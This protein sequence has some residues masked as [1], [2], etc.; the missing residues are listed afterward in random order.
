MGR[1][2]PAWI[3]FRAG[4]KMKTTQC[5]FDKRTIVLTL[6]GKEMKL[7][8]N[9]YKGIVKEGSIQ[10]SVK[11]AKDLIRSLGCVVGECEM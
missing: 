5:I 11:E 10:L 3:F 2:K 6:S 4:E 1:V 8:E 9:P 7:H